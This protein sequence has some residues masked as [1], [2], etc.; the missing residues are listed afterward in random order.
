MKLNVY[1]QVNGVAFYIDVENSTTIEILKL[2][3]CAS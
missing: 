3:I 2:K 1:N